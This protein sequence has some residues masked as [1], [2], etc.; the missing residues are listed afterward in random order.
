M[1]HPSPE[2]AGF[3]PRVYGSVPSS[4]LESAKGQAAFG[5]VRSFWDWTLPAPSLAT[6][7]AHPHWIVVKPRLT[8]VNDVDRLRRDAEESCPIHCHDRRRPDPAH[9]LELIASSR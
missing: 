5:G 7:L 4:R 2:A 9:D 8:P 1:C 3:A 6:C